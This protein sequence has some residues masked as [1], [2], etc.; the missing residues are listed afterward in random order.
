MNKRLKRY[1]TKCT[2]LLLMP[3]I[4]A[5]TS[6][7][8]DAQADFSG[9]VENAEDDGINVSYDEAVTPEPKD[10][11]DSDKPETDSENGTEADLN[12]M[13]IYEGFLKGDIMIEKE[14]EQVS[15]DEL[16]WDNDMEYC[17]ADIDGDGS[18]ELYIRD[19]QFHYSIKIKDEKPQIVFER[20]ME[21]RCKA[22]NFQSLAVW[23]Y[24][25]KMPNFPAERTKKVI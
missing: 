4:A 21:E 6:C 5:L 2:I 7:G 8:S 22:G 20:N 24:L 13:E 9:I 18:E 15:I 17:F 16:F 12:P 1:I 11:N 14:E 25:R 23:K 3:A 19:S 10:L